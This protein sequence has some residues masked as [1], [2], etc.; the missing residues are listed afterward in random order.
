MIFEPSLR[1]L[2]ENKFP[3]EDKLYNYTAVTILTSSKEW[4]AIAEKVIKP[5]FFN[6]CPSFSENYDL[7]DLDA[8]P[9]LIDPEANEILFKNTSAAIKQLE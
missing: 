5:H 1:H 6:K 8:S 2:V 9:Q 7:E 3:L 4:P